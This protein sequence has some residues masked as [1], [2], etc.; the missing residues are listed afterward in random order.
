[1][2]ISNQYSNAISF[3]LFNTS[4]KILFKGFLR[5]IL[6]KYFLIIKI[7]KIISCDAFRNFRVLACY[8]KY[9][10]KNIQTSNWYYFIFRHSKSRRICKFSRP[11][12]K[13]CQRSCYFEFLILDLLTLERKNWQIIKKY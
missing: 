5:F 11:H 9:F 3:A 6:C 2:L 13:I 8:L 4:C 12:C 10:F 1:M 7:Y